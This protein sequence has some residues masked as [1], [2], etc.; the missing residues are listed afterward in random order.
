M[1]S[2]VQAAPLPQCRLMDLCVHVHLNV[3]IAVHM[4]MSLCVHLLRE[5]LK[6]FQT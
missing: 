4:C 5:G 2:N 1:G 6:M 3:Y